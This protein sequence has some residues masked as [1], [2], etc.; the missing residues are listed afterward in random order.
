MSHSDTLTSIVPA[1]LT[2][3]LLALRALAPWSAWLARR[4]LSGFVAVAAI[5]VIVFIATQALPSDPARMVLGPDAPESSVLTLQKQWGLD[6]PLPV[7]YFSWAGKLL[8][9]DLGISLDSHV[10]VAQLVGARAGNSLSLLG[11]VL[12]VM[13]PLALASGVWLALHR[14]SWIE[15]KLVSFLIALKAVPNFALA[16]GLVMLFATTVWNVL[17]AVSLLE[18]GRSPWSQPQFMLL[19]VATLVLGGFPYL[20]RL[21]RA[22]MIEALESEYV[23]AARLRGLPES[24]VVWRHALPNALIPAVQ[25]VALTMSVLLGGTVVIEVVFTYPGLG[26][27]L[28]AAIEMRD[29]PVVQALVLLIAGGVVLINLSADLLTVLLTP[30]LRTAL[31]QGTQKGTK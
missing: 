31:A 11:G 18:P 9:G 1:T 5:S 15:C 23:T 20:S 12:A 26:S 21:V 29:L 14:D 16:I 17:P 2:G 4:L 10:P 25:G 28:N 6:R 22:S 27:A 24:R 7:Q 30:R 19:P 3:R 8:T 13:V